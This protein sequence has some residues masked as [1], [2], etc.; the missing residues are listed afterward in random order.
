MKNIVKMPS[1]LFALLGLLCLAPEVGAR[2]S[3]FPYEKF[4]ILENKK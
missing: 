1:I 4:I 2:L 3:N